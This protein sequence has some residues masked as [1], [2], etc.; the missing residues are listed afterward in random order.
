MGTNFAGLPREEACGIVAHEISHVILGHG[1]ETP[2][3]DDER[4][5]KEAEASLFLGLR[6][7]KTPAD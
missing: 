3:A 2:L 5:E 1:S 4:K 7:S 6:A